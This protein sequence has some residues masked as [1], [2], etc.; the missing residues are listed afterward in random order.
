MKNKILLH[1][2]CAP[3]ATYPFTVLSK[4]FEVMGYFY[5]SN[6]HPK[7]EYDKRLEAVVKLSKAWSFPTMVDKY[8]PQRWLKEVEG[9][10]NEPEGGKR[11][12]R[13]FYIQLKRATEIAKE[14]NIAIFTTTLTISPHKDVKL[15]NE[16][17]KELAKEAGL[18]FLDISF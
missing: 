9:L 6:I 14:E 18:I 12:Q 5:G 2:C 13:C 1:I 15:I 10:E 8:D 4:E 17:G 16:I 7:D 3:D 11:C